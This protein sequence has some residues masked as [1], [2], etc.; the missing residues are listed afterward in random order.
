[1]AD[2]FQEAVQ[3]LKTA[4]QAEQQYQR[5]ASEKG[6]EAAVLY[7]NGLEL[8]EQAIGLERHAAI[9]P[10][11]QQKATDV[12]KKIRALMRRVDADDV[13]AT[14]ARMAGQ[15]LDAATTR[16]DALGGGASAA[17]AAPAP[18][19]PAMATPQASASAATSPGLTPLP[20]PGNRTASYATPSGGA[21]APADSPRTAQRSAALQQASSARE[22]LFDGQAALAEAPTPSPA[23]AL[24]SPQPSPMEFD[25]VSVAKRRAA[26]AEQRA[27]AAEQQLQQLDAALQQEQRRHEAAEQRA[28]AAEQELAVAAARHAAEE[29]RL[30]A[31]ASEA[32]AEMESRL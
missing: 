16:L 24:P 11:L 29:T 14:R 5:G 18:A 20:G 30:T 3:V 6:S 8:L 7:G 23:A 32:E 15:A 21:E 13:A 2:Y 27:A 26:A 28:L 4:M 19:P 1:M 9:R 31:V 22:G 25:D 12:K 10:Q 17:E